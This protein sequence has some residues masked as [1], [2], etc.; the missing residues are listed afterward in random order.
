MR[1]VAVALFALSVFA[2]PKPPVEALRAETLSAFEHHVHSREAEMERTYHKGNGFL[3]SDLAD[4]R[5]RRVRAGE[6][7]IEPR[8][9]KGLF[10][11]K[12][13]LIH[14]WVGAAF[15]PKVTLATVLKRVQDY[16]KHKQYYRPEVVDSKLLSHQGDEYRVYMRLLKKKVL[17]VVLNTEHD[18]KYYPVDA[19]KAYSKSYT[20]KIAELDDPGTAS[21]RELKPGSDHGFLW[22]LNSYWRFFER[23]GGVYVECEAISLS[24]GVPLGLTWV[25]APILRDLPRE[26]LSH[27]LDATRQAFD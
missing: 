4:S 26:S 23:D 18:V 5:K 20:T 25:L 15:I 10:E 1:V 6:V 13:G 8:D 14:D 22:R 16:D 19:T 9:G 11:I 12:G 7:V 17:T 3:W 24:R 2:G 27:T 21:E